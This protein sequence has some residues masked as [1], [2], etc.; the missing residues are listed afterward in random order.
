MADPKIVDYIE[1]QTSAGFSENQIR[2]SLSKAGWF[3]TEI[4]E[5]FSSMKETPAVKHE[6]L[7][8]LHPKHIEPEPVK[9]EPVKEV[10]PEIV[11]GIKPIPEEKPEPV[12]VE[13]VKEVKPHVEPPKL[14]DVEKK[15]PVQK[16]AEPLIKAVDK[17]PDQGSP[18]PGILSMMP[19]L[20]SIIG[21]ALLL[22]NSILYYL[23]VGDILGLLIQDFEFSVLSTIGL[24]SASEVPI[25][26]I[27]LGIG[28]IINAVLIKI[29]PEISRTTSILMIV[30]SV[31]GILIG[32]GF[33][34]GSIIGLV[35]GIIGIIKKF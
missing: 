33:L 11:G 2:E 28:L 34:I 6:L 20:F 35:G 23:E 18:G 17:K 25:V 16:P 22:V 1:K 27:V 19:I 10:K 13:P 31:V 8:E 26:G 12:K 14:P 21:G 29:G 5:A 24:I 30:L 3:G 9:V 32:N 4:E 15:P 7:P